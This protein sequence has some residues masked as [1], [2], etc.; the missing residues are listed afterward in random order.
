MGLF[1]KQ[2]GN[3]VDSCLDR[4]LESSWTVSVP[5]STIP[6]SLHF[7][8]SA[9]VSDLEARGFG[10]LSEASDPKPSLGFIG[11]RLHP[12]EL[13]CTSSQILRAVETEVQRSPKRR[14]KVIK[15]KEGRGKSPRGKT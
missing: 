8:S 14:K 4:V 6:L 9:T 2:P 10:F 7:S 13:S 11:G 1:P 12:Q 5:P 15:R 3:S